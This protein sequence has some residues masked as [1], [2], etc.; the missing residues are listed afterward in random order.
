MRAP[1]RSF[2]RDR[3]EL[4][5]AGATTNL[6]SMEGLRGLAGLLT[7]F[8]HYASL[9][10]PW[11]PAATPAAGVSKALHDVGNSG[12][13][14]FFVLSGYLIY[15]MLLARP[16]PFARFMARRIQRIYPAFLA[17]FALYVVLSFVFPAENKIPAPWTAGASYLLANLLLLPG[18]FAIEPL[19]TVAWS[20]S[21]EMFFY[22]VI[23]LVVAAFGLRARTRA[24]RVTF[25][26]AVL[27]AASLGIALL[28]GHHRM[29]LFGAGILLYEALPA[30]EVPTPASGIGLTGLCVALAAA[31]LVV[32]GAPAKVLQN[33]VQAGGFFLLCLCC[34]RAQDGWLARA[35]SW[36][37]IRWIGNMSYSYYLLNGLV[38]KGASVALPRVLPA[39][40]QSGALWPALLL[41]MVAA[42]LL[43]SAVFF[44]A[45]ER[46]LS[47][48]RHAP[49]RR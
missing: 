15:G 39:G 37:P 29:L 43:V 6:P 24:W 36:T 14:L 23:P 25:F 46:P 26:A 47:L 45:V 3:F 7:F 44:L 12:V 19:I 28:G 49:G 42:T 33:L 11:L 18:V 48:A 34:F 2:L 5:R 4:G 27:L 21:Y 9:L 1:E 31:L 38:L 35:F 22:L 16:Q 20:L 13:D 32:S 10:V 30:R 17:V 41:P 8:V 40:F